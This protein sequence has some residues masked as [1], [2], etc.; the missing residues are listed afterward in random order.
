M[1]IRNVLIL[2]GLVLV[3]FGA[4]SFGAVKISSE[5]LADDSSASFKYAFKNIPAPSKSDAGGEGVF[6]IADGQQDRNGRGVDVLGDGRLA[7]GADEPGSSFFFAPNT[8]GGR[9]LLDL[10]KVIAIKQVNSYSW[11]PSTRGPQ[12]Y[13]LYATDGKGEGVSLRPKRGTDPKTCGWE[14]VA[15]VDTREKDGE[16]GGQ[17]GVSISDSDGVI[18][19]YRYLLF[20]VFRTESSDPF[21]N[22]FYNEIDVVDPEG[23]VVSAVA[24]L[25]IARE[26]IEADGGK[27]KITID[28]TETPD[29]TKWV[30]EELGPVVKEWYPRIV[31]M[32]PGE[33]YEAPTDVQIVFSARMQGVAATGGRRV[34]CAAG[35]FRGQLEG[36]AKGAVVHELVHVVQQYGLARRNR[37]A[38]RTPG[39]LVEGM[40]DYIRWFLYEPETRGAEI[41]NAARARYDGSYRVS[42]NF[43]NWVTETKDKDI[44]A[45]LNAAARQGKYSEDIWKDSTGSSV[46]ELGAQWKKALEEKIAAEAAAATMLNKLTDEERSAGWKLIFNGK[47]FTGWRNFK[48]E[49]V[50]PGWQVRDGALVCADPHNAGDLCTKEQFDWFELRLEYNI[51]KGGNSGIMYHVTDDGGAAWATGPEFQLEDNKAAADP[52]RC[53]WLY[54]LYEPPKDPKTGKHLDATKPAGQWNHVSILISPEKCEHRINGVKY[55][56]YVLGSEDFKNRVAK[57]KFGRMSLFAKFDKGYIALQGDHGAIS[58]RNIKV[59]PIK[60]KK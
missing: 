11:H 23:K 22:T 56:E 10:G 46:E 55:F 38:T 25:D 59:R 39:W 49:D 1:K 40:A 28:T 26:V 12:V 24:E 16:D 53:G 19:K 45:K 18:G 52:V 15:K 20:D 41:R 60:A 3:V 35:W 5:R 31:K 36:E 6:S 9:I 8:D 21:G 54:A 42:G 32:L 48:R 29:L 17:Y 58:F 30:H 57:S 44:V 14:L 43:L 50:R 7:M 13:D 51:S 2:S 34:S 4:A 27:Y 33:G 37:D 47:D